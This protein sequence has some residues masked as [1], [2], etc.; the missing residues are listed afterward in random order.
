L[1]GVKTAPSKNVFSSALKSIA[2]SL[3]ISKVSIQTHPAVG[4]VRFNMI[5][6]SKEQ[7]KTFKRAYAAGTVPRALKKF[8]EILV[9]LRADKA[10]AD[11]IANQ[12]T[13]A[14]FLQEMR[15]LAA[16]NG[17]EFVVS[18]LTRTVLDARRHWDEGSGILTQ[19]NALVQG[20]ASRT[21]SVVDS[22]S[23]S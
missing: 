20:Q 14:E 16:R 22:D 11:G 19:L 10:T 7:A 13:S 5:F 8:V 17:I 2:N 4:S 12:V 1:D 18:G 3:G 6:A 23:G 9:T 15:A 21:H